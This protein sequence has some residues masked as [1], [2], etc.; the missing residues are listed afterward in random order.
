M[1]ISDMINI[2]SAINKEYGNIP[3]QIYFDKDQSENLNID[4]QT[5]IADEIKVIRLREDSKV[6]YIS[7]EFYSHDVYKGYICN[8]RYCV[9]DESYYCKIISPDK[10][11]LEF[12]CKHKYEIS[13]VFINI[14]DSNIQRTASESVLKTYE[15]I[16][17]ILKE[18]DSEFKC[19]DS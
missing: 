7:N 4:S 12:K 9:E 11:E 1:L 8:S 19:G 15:K 13:K 5:A 17:E 10:N 14:V 6:A 18:D 2:L 16:H 3:V